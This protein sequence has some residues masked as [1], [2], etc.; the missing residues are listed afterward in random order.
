MLLD[1]LATGARLP[2]VQQGPGFPF[3]PPPPDW[4]PAAEPPQPQQQYES[5]DAMTTSSTTT[6]ATER[7]KWPWAQGSAR[8]IGETW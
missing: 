2:A 3:V 4:E 1:K 7:P 6:G 8:S 5:A